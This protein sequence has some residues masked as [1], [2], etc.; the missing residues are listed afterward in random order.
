MTE[1]LYT[2]LTQQNDLL[3]SIYV[4]LLFMIGVGAAVGV[5]VLLYKFL[6]LFF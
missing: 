3:C 1:Q 5:L 2:M 6:R 4:A